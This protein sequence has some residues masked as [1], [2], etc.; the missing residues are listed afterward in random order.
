MVRE[1]TPL[2]APWEGGWLALVTNDNGHHQELTFDNGDGH[3]HF[4]INTL[5]TFLARLHE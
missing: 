1:G 5:R 2:D 3:H 4:R